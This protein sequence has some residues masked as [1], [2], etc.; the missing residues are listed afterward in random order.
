MT[1]EMT[2]LPRSA[3]PGPEVAALAP[4]YRDWTWTGEIVAGGMGPGSPAMRGV[5]QARCRP[6]MGGLWYDCEFEQ[7]Q[8]LADGT[9]V[10]T[11]HLAWITGWDGRAHEYRAASA[12]DQGPTPG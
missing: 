4:F 12:D 3:T 10:L 5:G 6:V 7:D 2:T 8:R 1:L 11:W 9:H